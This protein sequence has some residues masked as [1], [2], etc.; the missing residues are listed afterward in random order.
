MNP[1]LLWWFLATVQQALGE[2]LQL[3]RSVNVESS[4][5]ISSITQQN[6][7]ITTTRCAWTCASLDWCS[8]WCHDGVLGC[9]LTNLIVSGSHQTNQTTNVRF[10]YTAHSLLPEYAFGASITSTAPVDSTRVLKN[11]IDGVYNLIE[12]SCFCTSYGF[13]P[14]FLLNLK[15]PV[16]VSTV[17][18]IAQNNV[19]AQ[20]QFLKIEVRVGSTQQ[21]GNFTSYTLLGTFPG[22]GK[23]GQIVTLKSSQP[24][25][26]QYVSV[27]SMSTI[28]FL[29]CHIEIN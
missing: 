5:F 9:Q 29:V 19:Y 3:W 13:Q 12:S 14:W 8:L 22:P 2:D 17:L 1:V 15:R 24:I 10:C 28:Y 23:V 6:Y 16:Y 18:L 7:S 27:Q 21:A 26:G 4:W 11:L 25:L 20:S